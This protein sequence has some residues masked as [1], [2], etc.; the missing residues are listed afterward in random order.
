MFAH[1]IAVLDARY[2]FQI[3]LQSGIKPLYIL[4]WLFL[5]L[6]ELNLFTSLFSLISAVSFNG[7]RHYFWSIKCSELFNTVYIL[8]GIAREIKAVIIRI[9]EMLYKCL[10][11]AYY[12][13]SA[14]E[15]NTILLILSSPSL[16]KRHC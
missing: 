12:L 11:N 8:K 14:L 4:I 16:L 2:I 6:S 10:P 13:Q 5:D 1:N 3:S 9:I 7:K 15:F